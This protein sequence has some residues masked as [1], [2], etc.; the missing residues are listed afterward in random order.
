MINIY[1][2]TFGQ[3]VLKQK[4]ARPIEVGA[5]LRGDFIYDLKDNC[6]ADNISD[7]NM[8]FG[9]LTGLYW[10]WKND[11]SPSNDVIGFFH[12]N[13]GLD[14]K[15]S[16][17]TSLNR[18]GVWYVAR[19]CAITPHPI[20]KEIVCTRDI[21]IKKFPQYLDTWDSIYHLD[22]SS[23][24]CNAAQMFVTTY[25]DF[26]E[27]CE[28]LFGVLFELRNFI[29]EGEDSPYYK[30]YCA[31]M[32]ERLLT[33]YLIAN[34]KTIIEKGKKYQSEFKTICSRLLDLIKYN[35]DSSIYLF[36]KKFFGQKSSYKK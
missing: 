29:G 7:L 13:K 32:G 8:Y 17:L 35:R 22:G 31:F 36:F 12:Y 20:E 4:Y 19:K 2:S 5:A 16:E 10:I 6:T 25:G 9:E 21:I 30:R 24:T 18:G 15:D 14:I 11:T 3:K 1:I 23:Q 33:V 28:F 27:Y 26:R 34:N